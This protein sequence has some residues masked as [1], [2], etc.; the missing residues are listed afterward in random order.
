MEY[1]PLY[2]LGYDKKFGLTEQGEIIDLDK[3]KPLKLNKKNQYKLL[4]NKGNIEYISI[5]KIYRQAYNREYAKDDI[6]SL[7]GE[8]WKEIDTQG[9]YY[10]SSYGRVK[11]YQGINARI[12]KPSQNKKGYLRVYLSA[13]NGKKKAYYIHRLVAIAFIENNDNKK[14]TVDH[15]DFQVQNNNVSNLCW[16]SRSDNSKRRRK[17]KSKC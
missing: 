13:E 16:L 15:I 2:K 8:I 4:N 9:K 3:S 14:D 7:N 5:K 11:S 12:L 10:I 6:K 17:R 1:Y